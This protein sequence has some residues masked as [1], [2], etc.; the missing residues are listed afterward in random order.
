LFNSKPKA[1]AWMAASQGSAVACQMG[2]KLIG[3]KTP[4]GFYPRVKVLVGRPLEMVEQR[5]VDGRTTAGYRYCDAVFRA[6]ANASAQRDSTVYKGLD[7]AV[8]DK[9][10]QQSGCTGSKRVLSLVK[11][12]AV[13]CEL[14][15]RTSFLGRFQC[16]AVSLI[17]FLRAANDHGRSGLR[18]EEFDF[19]FEV[20]VG[21]LLGQVQ[22]QHAAGVTCAS[23][24]F[25]VRI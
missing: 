8:T 25:S 11:R 12:S 13:G 9:N 19:C 16:D 22:Q 17:K 21:I 7:L 6:I 3:T 23:E 10:L 14:A 20:I 18:T 2:V 4:V 5:L 1:T 15:N 24:L